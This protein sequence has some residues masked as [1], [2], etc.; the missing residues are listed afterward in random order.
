MP[1][2]HRELLVVADDYGIGPATSRGIL[3]LASMGALSAT[4]LMVNT[5]YAEA[6]IERWQR[7]NQPLAMGWHPNLTLDRP[8]L[9]PE[10][11]PSLVD[12]TGQFWKLGAFVK[13]A[14]LGR[15]NPAELEAELAAQ[16]ELFLDLVGQPPAL[17]N[18]HQHTCI[19]GAVGPA[20]LRVLEKKRFRP[21][22][23]R[24]RESWSTF[25][26]VRGARLKRVFLSRFA[27][28]QNLRQR[29]AGFPGN[30]GFAGI[31]DPKWVQ[32]P[33]FFERWLRHTPGQ[34][35]E[36][37]CHPGYQD[38]TL[39]QRDSEGDPSLVQRRVDELQLL[40]QPAFFKAIRKAGFSLV[41]PERLQT[42]E[43]AYAHA[44]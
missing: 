15:L 13:K 37:M 30:D 6:D 2:P 10:Q 9:S 40:H 39:T 23:R 5:P 19:F 38:E 32:D 34:L 12:E 25:W 42:R 33:R 11:V 18:S 16:L 41:A 17:V 31:T 4:V 8:V 29:E 26:N 35:V 36:L 28:T 1:R 44:A 3:D 22:I 43:R 21:Y 24:I 7:A 14:I 27:R 20:L